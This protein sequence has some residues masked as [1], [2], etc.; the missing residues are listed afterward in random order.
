MQTKIFK[1]L[2]D[3]ICFKHLF[4]EERFL[5][6]FLNSFFDYIGV[7]KRVVGLKVTTEMEMHGTKRNKKI[8]YGDLMAYLDTDEIVSLEMYKTFHEREFKKSLSYL[9]RAFSDQLE[10]GE[11]YML[12][13]KVISI[14]LMEENYHLNNFQILN[15][16]GFVNKF[17][18]GRMKDEY[19]EMYLVRL[20]LVSKM[21]YN[22]LES[23]F[24]KWLKFIKAG[25][26]EEMG[27]IAKGDENMERALA[28][29]ERFVNDEEVRGI[30]DKINDV[31][32]DAKERGMAE[33]LAEG[34][35]KG[36][37]EGLA[38]GLIQG[39][40]A[41]IIQTAKNML[42]MNFKIEDIMEV[43]GLS[44]EEIETLQ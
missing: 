15:N 39:K 18:Y 25:S 17:N 22:K 7:K 27:K 31:E 24:L 12:A 29:M 38:E 19:L 6:D 44:I 37:A 43:T 21:V 10:Q 13:K 34:K 16:Y 20:D 33:G 26:V 30:Y 41:G 8:F 2:T 28:F 36:L 11:D 9:A 35:A 1:N 14:N 3:D 23:R 5:S 42:K 4:K 32:R 40:T